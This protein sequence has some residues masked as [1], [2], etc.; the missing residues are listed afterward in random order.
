MARN[1]FSS[2]PRYGGP[3]NGRPSL[4]KARFKAKTKYIPI[5]PKGPGD[6]KYLGLPRRRPPRP[7][8]VKVKPKPRGIQLLSESGMM[9]APGTGTS[10]Q[11]DIDNYKRR[12]RRQKHRREQERAPFAEGPTPI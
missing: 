3:A 5:A 1:Q 2:G 4:A 11:G 9:P 12:K 10:V 6:R 8:P 7:G